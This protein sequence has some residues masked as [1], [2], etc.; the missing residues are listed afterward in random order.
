MSSFSLGSLSF[1]GRGS[2]LFGLVIGTGTKAAQVTCEFC[3]QPTLYTCNPHKETIKHVQRLFWALFW[4]H[5]GVG[6]GVVKEWVDRSFLLKC[7]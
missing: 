6:V 7:C 2:N 1:L 3:Q 4:V 5:F